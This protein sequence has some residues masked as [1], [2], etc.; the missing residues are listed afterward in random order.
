M[1]AWT[2]RTVLWQEMEAVIRQRFG[3]HGLRVFRLLLLHPQLEQ[4]QIAEKA[5]LPPKV[6]LHSAL[7]FLGS[8][9]HHNQGL[10]MVSCVIAPK[11]HKRM[12]EPTYIALLRMWPMLKCI[13]AVM[14]WWSHVRGEP[15]LQI[16]N[17][18]TCQWCMLCFSP[19]CMSF[20]ECLRVY[21]LVL[22]YAYRMP[23]SCCTGSS[24]LAL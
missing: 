12:Q 9:F 19:S 1:A 24:K 2:S 23:R 8:T 20:L 7:H 14:L 22:F 3:A 13:D 18:Y 6:A 15:I 10:K 11:N 4:K 21:D 17:L 16:C 5:M